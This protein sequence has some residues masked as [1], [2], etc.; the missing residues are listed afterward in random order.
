MFTLNSK[1]TFG[2]YKGKKVSSV[3]NS[4]PRYVEWCVDHVKFFKL[5]PKA[6]NRLME[7]IQDYW[8]AYYE[9][10]HEYF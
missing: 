2:M 10:Y 8:D 6:H 5:D 1:F 7:R 9:L 3:I 4:N